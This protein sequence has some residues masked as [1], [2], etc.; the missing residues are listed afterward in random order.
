MS[1][2]PEFDFLRAIGGTDIDIA[3]PIKPQI[4]AQMA[5]IL[6]IYEEEM[7]NGVHHPFPTSFHNWEHEALKKPAT[8]YDC[9]S[10]YF[11]ARERM[12]K[13]LGIKIPP[14]DDMYKDYLANKAKEDV[15]NQPYPG[16][17]HK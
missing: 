4:D 16:Q 11:F 17:V 15:A 13:K 1:G 14:W 5:K 9:I 3:A 12:L 6:Y 2:C 8:Q 10:L 7:N